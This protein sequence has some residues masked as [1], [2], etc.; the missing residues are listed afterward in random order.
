MKPLPDL[1]LFLALTIRDDREDHQLASQ[2]KEGDRESFRAFYERYQ[3][4]L[5]SFLN[6]RNIDNDGAKR[7][8]RKA[9]MVVWD[10]RSTIQPNRSLRA[11]LLRIVY[12]RI[13]THFRDVHMAQP[14][15]NGREGFTKNRSAYGTEPSEA[16]AI[17]EETLE[18]MPHDRRTV[19]E[20]C[21][22]QQFPYQRIAGSMNIPA[23][24][25]E[26]HMRLAVQDL[27]NALKK[28]FPDT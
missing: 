19:F 8:L 28:H 21:Y 20:L 12:N 24:S 3:P 17:L 15:T 26:E 22:L 10:N 2:I 7:L 14:V 6:S 25:V 18:Q 16:T 1:L 27:R 9:F 23:A 13:L 5:S 4:S 11:F